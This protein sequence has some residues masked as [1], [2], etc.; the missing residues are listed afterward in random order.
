MS[1]KAG[2]QLT[3]EANPDYWQPD[4]PKTRESSSSP[5][6]TPPRW[7]SISGASR[8]DWALGLDYNQVGAL[9]Q[10]VS[11]SGRRRRS[12][13]TGRCCSTSGA[14][15]SRTSA[16][17]RAISY[18]LDRQKVVQAVLA[19]Q[20]TATSTPFYSKSLSVYKESDLNR[21]PFDLDRAKSL[22]ES[23]GVTNLRFEAMW[24]SSLPQ[25]G[26]ILEILQADLAKIGVTVDIKTFPSAQG[27]E[28][29]TKADFDCFLSAL[30]VPARDPSYPYTLPPML[31]TDA[32]E[33]GSATSIRPTRGW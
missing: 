26:P 30:A 25:A 9:G 13:A 1:F 14:R 18:A 21:Y 3:L 33:L 2:E 17:G 22:F 19:G 24:L 23:A 11:R 16:Y 20:S 6:P 27:Q 28:R 31:P 7:C 32:K 4:L 29:Y 15:T 5:S 12:A 10:E 8:S